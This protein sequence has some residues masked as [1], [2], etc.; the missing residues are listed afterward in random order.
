[1]LI[2]LVTPEQPPLCPGRKPGLSALLFERALLFD[3]GDELAV[4]LALLQ[5]QALLAFEAFGLLFEI[6]DALAALLEVL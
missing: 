5:N 4:L 1:V 2:V 6:G 3:G